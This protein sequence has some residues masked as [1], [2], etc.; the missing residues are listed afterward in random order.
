MKI[1][2]TEWTF[3]DEDTKKND[4]KRVFTIPFIIV[5]FV[6]VIMTILTVFLGISNVVL[7]EEIQKKEDNILS[8]NAKIEH[9]EDQN[10]SLQA[11]VNSYRDSYYD[12]LSTYNFYYNH[13]ACVDKHS[14]YYH[15]YDCSDFDSSYFW[16]FNTE[17]ARDEGYIPCPKCWK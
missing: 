13:A 17:Y 15:K 1:K 2:Q 11:E 4:K 10:T 14:S 12:I 9:Q 7:K 3:A 5:L 6:L 16:I 8:L